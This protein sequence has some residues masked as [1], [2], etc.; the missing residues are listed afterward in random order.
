MSGHKPMK[1][2]LTLALCINAS[3]DCKIKR[4][5]AYYWEKLMAFKSHK[6]LN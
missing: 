1:D 4:L 6:I 3:G 2:S 5:L